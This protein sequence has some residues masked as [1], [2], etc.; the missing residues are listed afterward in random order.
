ME[1]VITT[2]M[3]TVITTE[4][5]NTLWLI[6]LIAL[7]GA[8]LGGM[9]FYTSRLDKN[10]KSRRRTILETGGSVLSGGLLGAVMGWLILAVSTYLI[11]LI[12]D[13][14]DDYF[15]NC[16]KQGFVNCEK[17]VVDEAALV[18]NIEATYALE[19][20]A[21]DDDLTV[22]TVTDSL[23]P[24]SPTFTGIHDSTVVEFVVSVDPETNALDI[25]VASPAETI[26][27]DELINEN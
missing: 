22:G 26:T 9:D 6:V 12:Y 23:S 15:M 4:V 19:R 5:R 13:T 11:I 2:A 20:V 14:A 10:D 17:S 25:A 16:L 27:V 18:D 1:T 24:D 21:T 7:F 8:V 3:E